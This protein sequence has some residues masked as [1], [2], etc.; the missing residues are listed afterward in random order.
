VEPLVDG[1]IRLNGREL[2][3]H[4]VPEAIAAG[5]SLVPENRKEQG[6]LLDFAI[7]A[8]ISL[9]CLNKL[10]RRGV[11]NRALEATLAESSRDRLSI[12]TSAITRAA[13]ELSGGNQQKVVLAKWLAM[14]PKVLI[15]DE[16]TRGIDVGAKAEVYHL[17]QALAD[18]GVGILMISSD[19]EEVI[20]VSDRVAVM[21]RGHVSGILG[22]DELTE[23]NILRLAVG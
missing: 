16:P 1:A 2:Q 20:G 22:R 4:S 6:L 19:M 13:A 5:L 23:E 14:K 18:E 21:R 11:V 10:S 7:C 17:M 12:K 8:N 9:P 3:T 15:F